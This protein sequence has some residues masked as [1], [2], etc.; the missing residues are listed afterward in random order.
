MLF[1]SDQ[2]VPLG[3]LRI[4]WTG[5]RGADEEWSADALTE[6]YDEEMHAAPAD[7]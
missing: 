5:T 7:A 6:E 2:P 3:E 1:R 4:T